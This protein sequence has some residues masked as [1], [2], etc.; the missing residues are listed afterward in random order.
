MDFTDF[1][2]FKS[3]QQKDFLQTVHSKF[4]YLRVMNALPWKRFLMLGFFILFI[5]VGGSVGYYLLTGGAHSWL[6]YVYMVMITITTIGYGEIFDISQNPPA[7]IFTM[8]IAVSG[9][10]SLS[11]LLSIVTA[12]AVEGTISLKLQR[13]RMDKQ[14]DKLTGHYIV[15]GATPIGNYIISELKATGRSFVVVD[16]SLRH[17]DIPPMLE[18]ALWLNG[19]A[20]EDDAM[21][22]AGIDRAAGVFS[23]FEDDNKN[24]IVCFTARH[25][26]ENVRIVSAMTDIKNREK[27]M[28]AGAAAVISPTFIGGLR[29]TS[30]MVQPSAVTFLD[31]M[32]RDTKSSL[33]I[34]EVPV[35]ER[36]HGKPIEEIRAISGHE[37]LLLALV[38]GENYAF[39]PA[40]SHVLSKGDVLILMTNPLTRERLT[41]TV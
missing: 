25:L 3:R 35:T 4:L 6:D 33:R 13:S 27:L 1:Q 5:I 22:R 37:A 38:S 41:A 17:E 26:N 20:T 19:E 29:M 8:I 40:G 9:F 14:I 34:C 30:E 15:C 2:R 32:I 11:Y 24:L 12:A 16:H 18:N 28:R 21:K 23:A 7:R 31:K 10:A 39:N 36:F